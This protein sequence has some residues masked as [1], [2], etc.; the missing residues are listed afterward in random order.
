MNG[1]LNIYSLKSDLTKNFSNDWKLESGIKTSFVKT[2]NDLKFFNATTGI[3]VPD[4]N[5]TN[6]FIYEENINAVYGNLSKKWD[7]FKVIAGLR[8]ENTNVK[9]TQ[10]TTNQI[11]KR[12]YTQLFPSAVVAYDLNENSNLEINL[13]RRITRPSYNQLNPFKLYL[14]PTT[15]RA[16]NPDLNPQT[17]MNY[18][19]T[20]SLIIN[21][22][23]H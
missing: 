21:I 12:N 6:H 4:L 14:D 11:N 9:G 5:K 8:V 15:M 3:P 10:L 23:P 16:G 22:L 17:T 1:K 20:Y 19:L 18:E 2:D 13:S 7:K